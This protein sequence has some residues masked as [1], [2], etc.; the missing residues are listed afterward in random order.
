MRP[1]IVGRDEEDRAKFGDQGLAHLGKNYVRTGGK[2]NLANP[3]LLDLVRP[4]VILVSGKRGQGKSYTLGVIAEEI[5]LLP[6]RLRERLTVVIFDTMGIYWTMR[7]PNYRQE[8]LLKAWDLEPME[9][10][11]KVLIPLGWE[12][13]YKESGVVYDGFLALKPSE[14]TPEDWLL[15]FELDPLSPVGIALQRVVKEKAESIDELIYRAE[16]LNAE[17]R[18]KD[19]LVSLFET[20]Q[21]WGIFSEKGTALQEYLT[22][23]AVNVLDISLLG[24]NVKSLL[25]GILSRKIFYARVMAR[26]EEEKSQIMKFTEIGLERRAKIPMPWLVIDEAHE[27]LP[28]KGESP[29]SRALIQVIREGRQPGLTLVLATQQPGKIHSDVMT[30]ADIVL[31]HRVTAVLDIEA[32]NQIMG[33]YMQF[34]LERYISTL[35]RVKGAAVLL[36]DNAE[37]VYQIRV[38]PRLSWHGGESA[39]IIS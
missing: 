2:I 24:M 12:E 27:F 34:P 39:K 28:E 38:R 37:K 35:P 30:Q 1:I 32:L 20:A 6:R 33:T 9:I 22:P 18:V 23:G 8:D 3:V 15:T 29:S 19:A 4:H 25:I 13:L 10:E 5:A 7:Y 17:Q 31:S 14:L 11:T 16:Q 21:S 26:K 36:D